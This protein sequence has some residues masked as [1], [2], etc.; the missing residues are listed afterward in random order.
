MPCCGILAGE[1][2]VGRQGAVRLPKEQWVL[3]PQQP[4]NV[5]SRTGSAADRLVKEAKEKA[6]QEDLDGVKLEDAQVAGVRRL[7]Y[8]GVMHAGDGNPVATVNH[9]VAIALSRC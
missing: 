8:L 9:R 5:P 4:Q 7:K 6:T 1:E 2:E 3:L